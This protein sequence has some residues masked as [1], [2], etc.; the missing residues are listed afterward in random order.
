[1]VLQTAAISNPANLHK[2]ESPVIKMDNEKKTNDVTLK[3]DIK[4]DDKE[5]NEI[6]KMSPGEDNTNNLTDINK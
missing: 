3:E 6:N 2:A 5:A 4:D 1:V